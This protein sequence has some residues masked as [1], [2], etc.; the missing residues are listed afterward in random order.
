MTATGISANCRLPVAD[1]IFL[2]QCRAFCRRRRQRRARP[3]AGEI[4]A[5]SAFGPGE[6]RS[7]RRPAAADRHRQ[8]D[9][10]ARP[11]LCRVPAADTLLAR[12]FEGALARY[13]GLH[14]IAFAVAPSSL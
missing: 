9:C 4:C 1:E 11:R 8:R 5:D 13:R 3:R 14:L 10:D 7:R 6:S 2:D 12:E